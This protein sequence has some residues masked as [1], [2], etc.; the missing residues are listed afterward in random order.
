[1][2][3]PIH[4]QHLL[5]GLAA[6]GVLAAVPALAQDL[7]EL[8]GRTAA[9]HDLYW[10]FNRYWWLL[11]PL[12]WGIGQMVKSWQRHSRAKA[13]LE[14]LQSYAAQGKEPPSELVAVLRQ[15]DQADDRKNREGSF[16]HYGWVPVFL[17]GALTC[18][19]GLMAI[20]PPDKNIPV[21]VMPFVALIMLGLCIGNL[22][23]MKSYN[24]D[25][26][27]RP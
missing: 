13:A 1:M 23:A 15:P 26:I 2:K 18:G 4:T 17:F 14:A 19:F 7:P 21:V 20:F 6:I 3:H 22:V 11:F 24:K 5:I 27:D 9:P 25:R 10:L 12:A 16:R 8:S